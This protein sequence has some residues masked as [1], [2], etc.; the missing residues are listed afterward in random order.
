MPK[1]PLDLRRTRRIKTPKD[2]ANILQKMIDHGQKYGMEPQTASMDYDTPDGTPS[3]AMRFRTKRIKKSQPE[4][5][6]I[7]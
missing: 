6:P 5:G 3:V 7:P 1:P 2:H 4:G